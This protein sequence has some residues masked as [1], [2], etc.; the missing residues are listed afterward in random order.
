MTFRLMKYLFFGI[1]YTKYRDNKH[2]T[3]NSQKG[4]DIMQEQK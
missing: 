1:E 3:Q 2:Q 4:E